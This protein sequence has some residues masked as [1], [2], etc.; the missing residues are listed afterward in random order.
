MQFTEAYEKMLLS[1]VDDLWRNIAAMPA[2]KLEWKLAEKTRSVREILGEV[3][4]ATSYNGA[5]LTARAS[6]DDAWTSSDGLS[7]ED[8]EA[9]H[10]KNIAEFLDVV[11]AFPAEELS[12]KVVL[13]WGEMTY[14]DIISYGYWNTMYH[15]GQ[16]AYVQMMYGDAEM[17]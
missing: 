6:V 10:R 1:G 16:I 13:P 7:L 8:L 11:K 3:V 2:D 4:G 5:V 9:L 15:L 14:F 17:H 12:D